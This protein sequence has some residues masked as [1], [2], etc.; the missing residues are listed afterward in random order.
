[1]TDYS[2][3]ATAEFGMSANL[4]ATVVKNFDRP[5]SDVR[6]WET[7]AVIPDDAPV[8]EGQ[9]KNTVLWCRTTPVL[10]MDGSAALG[11]RQEPSE[12]T[13]DADAFWLPY[14]NSWNSTTGTW[15][16]W[17]VTGPAFGWEQPNI[18]DRPV[19]SDITYR[20]GREIITVP[21]VRFSGTQHLY[22]AFFTGAQAVT[23]TLSFVALLSGAT[24]GTYSVLDWGYQGAT[25]MPVT[26]PHIHVHDKID[27][28]WGGQNGSVDPLVP[29]A[30][31][32]PAYLTLVISPPEARLYVSTGPRN[33]Y[34]TVV[35]AKDDVG[36]SG[37]DLR[38]L[39]GKT[40][41]P[42]LAT[43]ATPNFALL[44]AALWSR[45]LNFGEINTLNANYA[46]VWGA[47]NEWS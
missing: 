41:D 37:T 26:R 34:S 23:F 31:M 35:T 38:F 19:F 32:R 20:L 33:S 47:S 43:A 30:S 15:R 45:P 12:L 8:F 11:N 22:S 24:T 29:V 9:P 17:V 44:G 13:L 25:T 7:M 27:Y 21:Q 36:I 28:G 16:P 4:L 46:S 6:P 40:L 18:P 42:L 3:Q 10:T 5:E 39:I 1:M 14:I 2:V